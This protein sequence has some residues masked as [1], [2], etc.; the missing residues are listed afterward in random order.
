MNVLTSLNNRGRITLGVVAI[1]FVAAAILLMRFAG[2]PSWQTVQTGLSPADTGKVTDALN[3]KGIAFELQQGGTAVA[4]DKSMA[5]QAR[6]ALA[7]AGVSGT[8]QPGFELLDKQ[9]LGASSFQQQVAYQRALEGQ[10][11]QTISQIEGVGNAQVRLSLPKDRLFADEAKPATAAVLLGSAG[12]VDAGAVRGIANLVASS[13]P[14]LKPSAV[15]V[16][17]TTGTMLWP[18]GEAGAGADGAATGKQAAQAR[19]EAQLSSSL[20]A[21]LTRTL[22]PDK[23]QVQVRADLDADRSTEEKLEYAAKGT[24]LETTEETESLKG[25]GGSGGAAGTTSNVPQFTAS[26]SSGGTSNYSKSSTKTALGVGKTVT[27]TTKATG[28]VNKLSVSVLVDDKAVDAKTLPAL[29]RAIETAAGIDTTRGDTL[30]VQKVPFAELPDAKAVP[31]ALPI[32]DQFV[33]PAK[34]IGIGLAALLFLFF[35]TR[36]LRR[37]EDEAI[38]E[39]P[40]WLKQL[41]APM[42]A[43]AAVGPGGGAAGAGD[44]TMV[45]PP[46]VAFDD[47]RKMAVEDLVQ[48]EPERVAAQLRTWIQEDR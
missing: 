9:K 30:S 7:T 5:A 19:Y 37:R 11:A 18:T 41:Q 8:S 12:G 27:R 35:V 4:V 22:G 31:K 2:Q 47:P 38:A 13:V 28:A 32:P 34:A 44:S 42:P 10:I 15:T 29:Q 46:M 43:A 40:S 39:A 33:G 17:D 20:D 48:R 23:A 24:P 3:D 25:T 1:G 14:D 21:M 6:I 36:H 16:T 26:G 45:I